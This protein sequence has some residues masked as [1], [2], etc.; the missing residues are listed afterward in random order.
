MLFDGTY[1]QY[2]AI[3]ILQIFFNLQPV[4]VGYT[5]FSTSS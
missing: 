5:H 2:A 1:R 4:H 3:I